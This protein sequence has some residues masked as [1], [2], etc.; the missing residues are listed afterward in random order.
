V[1]STPNNDHM[2]R[3]VTVP[4]SISRDAWVEHADGQIFVRIWS[5]ST[6]EF[7]LQAPIVLFHDSLGCVDL[8]RDFPAKLSSGSRRRVIAYDRLGFGRSAVRA[9]KLKIDFIADEAKTYFPTIREQLGFQKFI[10]FGHS[11]GGAMA[12][13][14]AADFDT[15]CRA[16]ITESAQV[17][18]ENQT[19]TSIT[20]A[21]EQFKDPEQF[22]RLTKYHGKKAEWVLNA[23]TES[24]LHPDFGSWSLVGVLPQVSCPVLAIHGEFDEYGSSR[25]PTLIERLCNGPCQVKIM[26]DT[27]HVPHRER[28][29]MVVEL[30]SKF[31][32]SFGEIDG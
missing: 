5:P 27:Y 21:R 12:I 24:W 7:G 11:V 20:N 3:S 23:W 6:E 8:W 30:V 14:C 26:R 18:A 9:D 13:N 4:D 15:D 2:P 17:F 28:P 25:H 31:I 29:E 10:S 22:R 16:L 1:A 32:A 19:L